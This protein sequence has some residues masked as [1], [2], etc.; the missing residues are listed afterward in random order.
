MRVSNDES[1]LSQEMGAENA[2]KMALDPIPEQSPRGREIEARTTCHPARRKG[3]RSCWGERGR[4]N[5]EEGGRRKRMEGRIEDEEREETLLRWEY[6]RATGTS[7]HSTPFCTARVIVIVSD[8]ITMA[9]D[10]SSNRIPWRE[11][12]K[13]LPLVIATLV[14][15][16]ATALVQAIG[17]VALVIVWL[18]VIALGSLYGIQARKGSE[19]SRERHSQKAD[20]EKPLTR[21][22]LE[23]TMETFQQNR[24]EA[25]AS[26]E[27][28]MTKDRAPAVRAKPTVAVPSKSHSKSSTLSLLEATV[29]VPI[30]EDFEL[31]SK[32]IK[33]GPLE[34][35]AETVSGRAFNLLILDSEEFRRYSEGKGY[36][37][38]MTVSNVRSFR[39]TVQIPR[40]DEWNFVV[41]A[42]TRGGNPGVRIV[43]RPIQDF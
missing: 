20:S 26:L 42:V 27:T 37:P 34:I 31:V 13:W 4:R 8:T 25:E 21:S 16:T 32:K 2:M 1:L 43:V 19:E 38:L 33:R 40:A 11:I 36:E 23:G 14:G 12:G 15:V 30:G 35:I 5:R 7:A 17:L 6:L 22:K 9:E 28:P 10:V 18:C 3:A 24:Q 41:E 29:T 39:D